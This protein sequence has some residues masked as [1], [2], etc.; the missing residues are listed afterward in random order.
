MAEDPRVSVLKTVL[1]KAGGPTRVSELLGLHYSAP[2]KWRKIPAQ[3]CIPLSKVT[4]V[5]IFAMRPDV[6]GTH[7]ELVALLTG[8]RPKSAKPELTRSSRRNPNPLNIPIG[9]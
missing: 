2:S 8:I 7:S 1:D 4:G 9:R 5:S 6:F 3:H